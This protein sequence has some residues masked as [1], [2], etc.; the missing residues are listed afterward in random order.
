MAKIENPKSYTGRDLET[1]FFRPMLTGPD[2]TS[3]GIK[4]MYNMPVPTTLQF[5]KRAGDILQKYTASGWNGGSAATKYQKLIQLSKVKAEVGYSADDYFNMVYELITNRS[6]VN[7]D[8]LSG[9]EL[10]AA[11]TAL[12]KEAIAESIRATMWL[13]DTSRSDTLN[14]FDGFLKRLTADIGSTDTDIKNTTIP[15]S[16]TANSDPDAAENLLKQVWNNASELA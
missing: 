2:A 11:E 13:G 1:I 15:A 14:T 7:L 5:W 8:D 3:L 10:E 9:T 16:F 12:F 4:I 6:D